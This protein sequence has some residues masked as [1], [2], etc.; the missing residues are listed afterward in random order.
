MQRLFVFLLGVLE[1]RRDFCTRI[2]SF[3]LNRSYNQGRSLARRFC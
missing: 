3:D 1:A 2:D